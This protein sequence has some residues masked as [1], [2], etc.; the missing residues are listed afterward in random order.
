MIASFPEARKLLRC[1]VMIPK[2]SDLIFCNFVQPFR[3][4]IHLTFVKDDAGSW[5]NR[6]TSSM[7]F[8]ELV[9][10]EYHHPFVKKKINIFRQ[11]ENYKT[12]W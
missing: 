6:F 9:Q 3:G 5:V 8:I 4:S 2:F 1:L 11:L 10:Y 7:I 12:V